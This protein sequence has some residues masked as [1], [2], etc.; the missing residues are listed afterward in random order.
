MFKS[1]NEKLHRLL[2]RIG[3]FLLQCIPRFFRVLRHLVRGITRPMKYWKVKGFGYACLTWW[4]ELVLLLFEFIGI[5]EVYETS[6]DW[7]KWN[8][9]GLNGHEK[10]LAKEIFGQ[11]LLLD[12]II[13][14]EK[15]YLGPKQHRFCYVSLFTLN[16]WGSM[17]DSIFVHELVHVWQ[18]Q[19]FGILYT[20]KALQAQYSKPGYD[21]G[22]EL[23][24]R[25]SLI[26]GGKLL[27][28]NFEQQASIIEDYQRLRQGLKPIW[29]KADQL[30]LPVYEYFV[31]QLRQ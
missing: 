6:A 3:Y 5:S 28:F 18:Y 21:Y 9:R 23:A 10:N 1:I 12:R 8:T 30:Y 15:S 24:L 4:L 29:G 13:I 25:Q 31:R 7:V 20:S 19:R 14:D 2:L 17:Q 26:T 16:S 27:D 11:N 22:G